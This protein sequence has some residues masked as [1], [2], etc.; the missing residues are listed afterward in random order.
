MGGYEPHHH[1]HHHQ[2]QQQHHYRQRHDYHQRT[3][4]FLCHKWTLFTISLAILAMSTVLAALSHKIADNYAINYEIEFKSQY[5]KESLEQALIGMAIV[6]GF[7]SLF[8]LAGAL[9]ESYCSTFTFAVYM[10]VNT[11]G[12]MYAACTGVAG[13]WLPAL[14]QLTITL[15]GWTFA[16]KLR[17]QRPMM[18]TASTASGTPSTFIVSTG[19]HHHQ[20]YGHHHQH[21]VVPIV[22]GGQQWT[23]GA[24]L[25]SPGVGGGGLGGHGL[26]NSNS[27]NQ[28]ICVHNPPPYDSHPEYCFNVI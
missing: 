15:V 28:W 11:V 9:R 4:L 22:A 12:N 17:L 20:Q 7:F 5:Q 3:A 10:G 25:L 2:Q 1:H 24:Q 23:T 19:R 13:V 14:I 26:A 6:T 16:R 18:R 21:I 8:G 27:N